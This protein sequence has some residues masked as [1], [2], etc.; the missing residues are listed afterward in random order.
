MDDCTDG[1]GLWDEVKRRWRG[2]KMAFR[3][4]RSNIKPSTRALLEQIGS[5]PIVTLTPVRR[6]LSAKIGFLV[7]LFRGVRTSLKQP[8]PSHDTLFHLFVVAR[9]QDGRQFIIEK[10]EDIN[11]IPYEAQDADDVFKRDFTPPSS[12]ERANT[13]S[14]MLE[15]A[16]RYMG[17][18][19]LFTYDAF[20]WNC[21]DFVLN[22][23]LGNG[24]NIGSDARA[25]IMQDVSELVPEWAKKVTHGVT[26]FYN[27]LKT[28]IYGEGVNGNASQVQSVLISRKKFTNA[29]SAADYARE[30]GF[31]ANK[32]DVTRHWYRFRQQ[33]PGKFKRYYAKRVDDGI[34]LIIGT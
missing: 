2:L 30:K 22:F 32:V 19:H 25:F 11:V 7:G 28:A 18:E 21:Q 34:L 10:N 5:I 15:A 33:S 23:L 20:S 9:L 6:V 26:S 27:R 17:D 14:V 29:E 8:K 1:A 24:I 4:I 31:K 3:G 12:S 16:R 13:I